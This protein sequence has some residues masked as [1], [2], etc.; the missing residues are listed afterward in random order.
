MAVGIVD[1]GDHGFPLQVH[2]PGVRP[3]VSGKGLGC[4][5]REDFAV[6][7]RHR[8]SG[9]V[10]LVDRQHVAVGINHLGFQLG[11]VLSGVGVGRQCGKQR[12][13]KCVVH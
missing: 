12:K 10:V 13:G 6:S 7:D 5:H 9:T 2:H 3:D 1:P 4:S 11:R 8:F